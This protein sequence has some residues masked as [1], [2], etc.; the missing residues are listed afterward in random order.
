MIAKFCA[1]LQAEDGVT[2]IEYALLAAGVGL[3]TM[4]MA[5]L[6]GDQLSAVFDGGIFDQIGGKT[7]E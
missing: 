2:G 4:T 6:V 3:G 5:W 7:L 1:W